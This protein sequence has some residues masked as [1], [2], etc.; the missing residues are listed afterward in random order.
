MSNS[1]LSRSKLITNDA[2]ELLR[3]D[4]R[5]PAE[6]LRYTHPGMRGLF[7]GIWRTGR[8]YLVEELGCCFGPEIFFLFG[9]DEREAR[10]AFDRPRADVRA[11]EAA[12]AREAFAFMKP[13]A[14]EFG[15][16]A[17]LQLVEHAG[18]RHIA[19]AFLPMKRVVERFRPHEWFLYWKDKDAEFRER[20]RT[21]RAA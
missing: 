15:G 4:V 7:G 11:S 12:A 13:L 2:V 14:R 21:E 20:R 9:A 18:D 6:A 16:E 17:E 5:L 1:L 3:H 8:T 10:E 19:R